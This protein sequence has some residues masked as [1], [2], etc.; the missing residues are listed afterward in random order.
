VKRLLSTLLRGVHAGDS[1]LA[2]NHA[3]TRQAPSGIE[4]RS[5]AFAHEGLIP[6]RF[7]GKGVGDNV[8]PEL[9]WT[10]V[11]KGAV[12][13][14]LVMEDPDAPLRRPFVHLIAYRVAADTTRLESRALNGAS[15]SHRYG[16]NTFGGSGYGGPRALP[17]HGPHRYVF[18]IFALNRPL[19]FG[20]P[21]NLQ[22]LLQAMD[23]AVIGRGR[24]DGFFEQK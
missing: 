1:H 10:G 20:R 2:W 8:S 17:G 11:P 4:L 19:S 12:E 14:A 18:Q 9:S 21:P 7:A 6:L 22:Q 15:D 5:S 3:A 13:L 23:G 16:R 24:L